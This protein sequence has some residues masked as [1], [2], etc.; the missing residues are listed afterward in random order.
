MIAKL[1]DPR[2]DQF[3]LAQRGF[4]L[5]RI[6][7]LALQFENTGHLIFDALVALGY[8]PIGVFKLPV[9][10]GHGQLPLSA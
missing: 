9:Q 4:G 10:V 1:D 6:I 3:E 2:Q 5:A 8:L 7:T